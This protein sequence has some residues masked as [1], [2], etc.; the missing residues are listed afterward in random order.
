MADLYQ[1]GMLSATLGLLILGVWGHVAPPQ[2]IVEIR[3]LYPEPVEIEGSSTSEAPRAEAVLEVA[4]K[5]TVIITKQSRSTGLQALLM[6]S[7]LK[8]PLKSPLR[9]PL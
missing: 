6:E 1:R 5:P 7:P 2:V 9:S 3:H 4:P 8:S